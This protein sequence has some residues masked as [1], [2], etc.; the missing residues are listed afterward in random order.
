MDGERPYSLRERLSKSRSFGH[1][2][3]RREVAANT[4]FE[5][6]IS[7]VREAVP[8]TEKELLTLRQDVGQQRLNPH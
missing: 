6:D 5:I 3:K 7:R 2:R 8:P 4:G 1:T